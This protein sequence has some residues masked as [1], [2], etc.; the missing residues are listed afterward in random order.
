M[1]AEEHGR[2]FDGLCGERFDDFWAVNAKLMVDNQ[3]QHKL[4]NI[5]M[6]FYELNRPFRYLSLSLTLSLSLD[7]PKSFQAGTDLPKTKA[8]GSRRD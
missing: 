8:A 2:L 5:P 4:L 1:T 7:Y 6:R 3:Q